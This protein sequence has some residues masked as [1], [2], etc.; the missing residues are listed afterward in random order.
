[1]R[2]TSR[3]ERLLLAVVLGL[4]VLLAGVLADVL[5]LVVLGAL[6]ATLADLGLQR[7]PDT[8]SPVQGDLLHAASSVRRLLLLAH[9]LRSGELAGGSQAAFVVLVAAAEVLLAGHRVLQVVDDRLRSR[10]AEVRN[11][12]GAAGPLPPRSGLLGGP[13]R[14]LVG[15]A[16]LLLPLSL[17][18]TPLLGSYAVVVAAAG[19]AVLLVLAVLLAAGRSLLPLWRRPRGDRLVR[20]AHEAVLA[21][22]PAVIVYL[23]EG[24]QDLHCLKGWLGTLE[25]LE[26]PAVVLLRDMDTLQRLPATT[27]PAV[28]VPRRRDLR[29]FGLPSARVALFVTHSPGNVDLVRD[30]TLASAHIGHGDSDKAASR[31]PVNALYDELWVAGPAARRR[32]LAGL[33][34][35]MPVRVVG[36][37]QVRGVQPARPLLPGTPL[38]VLYAP[39]WEGLAEDPYESSLLH[40]GPAIVRALLSSPDVEVVYRPHPKTG[41]RTAAFSRADE[42]VRALLTAAGP[43]HRVARPGDVDLYTCFDEVDVLVADI[44]GVV[45]DFLASDKPYFVVDGRGL[46]ETEFRAA[47]PSAAGAY[48][49]GPSG[50]GLAEGLQLARTSDP[51][52]PRRRETRADLLGPVDQDPLVLFRQAVDELGRALPAL[53]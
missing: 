17:A 49:V 29:S 22:A 2:A 31:N 16:E 1:M 28:C 40:S 21:H 48:L 6:T 26:R 11:L 13:G 43:Q 19:A 10:R 24:P 20:A 4:A 32:K 38:R 3:R 30:E 18:V 9:V 52:R 47:N 41:F 44:S 25:A 51:L 36:R 33:T 37:P 45:T 8:G 14:Q 50:A 35:P 27:L 34:R 23:S 12:P 42:Q 15:A 7:L 39:T 53:D 5:A 46:P